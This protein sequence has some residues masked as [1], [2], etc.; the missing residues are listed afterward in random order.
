MEVDESPDMT[1]KVIQKKR[2][3]GYM[4]FMILMFAMVNI[5]PDSDMLSG[6]VV[7]DTASFRKAASDPYLSLLSDGKRTY[8]INGEVV[9]VDTSKPGWAVTLLLKNAQ[10][11]N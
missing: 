3:A 2:A 1:Q 4:S 5:Q 11:S 6:V 10:G 8:R 7:R 9:T